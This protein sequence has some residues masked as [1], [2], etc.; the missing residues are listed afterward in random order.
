MAGW[1]PHLSIAAGGA[2]PSGEKW[3]CGVRM[4]NDGGLTY[5]Q[6]DLDKIAQSSAD[7]WRTFQSSANL[8]WATA[9]TLDG[10]TVRWIN[11]DGKTQ[12]LSQRSPTAAAPTGGAQLLPNQAAI[13]ATLITNKPGRQGMGRIYLPLLAMALNSS[14]N[15]RL[16]PTTCTSIA[17][18][19]KTLIN[20]INAGWDAALPN[21]AAPKARVGVQSKISVD[22]TQGQ[23][24][25]VR[26]GDV[27]DTQ[28]R[29]RDK[30]AENYTTVAL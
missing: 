27:I 24:V 28:R 9:V 29:R 4:V 16:G 6:A 5:A 11:A 14:F 20:N 17:T 25:A 7:A 2:M 23:V 10:C 3:S 19:V 18:A 30:I 26:V 13:V 21:I 8:G 22:S 1:Q 15:G 12:L